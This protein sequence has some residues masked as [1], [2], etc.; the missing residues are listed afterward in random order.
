MKAINSIL[1]DVERLKTGVHRAV[2]TG[3]MRLVIYSSGHQISI[4]TLV[5][6]CRTFAEFPNSQ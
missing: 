4:L 2:P 1:F 5:L 3:N 6:D